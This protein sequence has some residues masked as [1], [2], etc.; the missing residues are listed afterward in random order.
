MKRSFRGGITLALNKRATRLKPLEAPEPPEL[1]AVPLALRPDADVIVEVTTS[2]EVKVGTLLASGDLRV[3]SPV[4]GKVLAIEPRPLPRGGEVLT[5]VLANDFKDTPDPFAKPRGSVENLS[6]DDIFELAYDAGIVLADTCEP[7]YDRLRAAER[8]LSL[9]VI[10]CA[11]PEPYLTS[12][13]RTLIDS[14]DEVLAGARMLTKALAPSATVLA[15]CTEGYDAAERVTKR[16]SA[17]DTLTVRV[18]PTKYPQQNERA[19][20]RSLTGTRLPNGIRPEAASCLVV[21]AEAAASLC[22]AATTGAPLLT[23]AVTVAGDA[24]ANPK[25]L[26]VR[27]GTPLSSLVEAAGGLSRDPHKLLLGGV[28]SGV[29]LE[30]ADYPVTADTTALLA[31]SSAVTAPE[32]TTACIRCGRCVDACPEHIS[33]C[34]VNLLLERGTQLELARTGAM[35]CIECGACAYV[36]PAKIPL[37]ERLRAAKAAIAERE[38]TAVLPETTPETEVTEDA[39]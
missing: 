17:T 35:G 3:H 32:P 21:E 29:A 5:A 7:L 18:L 14:V 22:R 16:L 11:E 8:P 4:S 25:N 13:R 33:P 31:F 2:A 12:R 26:L 39:R 6:A 19:L 28:L 30:N 27:I 24:V 1:L 9:L 15:F 23:R 20:V 34:D 38:K 37:T 10:N 36:C